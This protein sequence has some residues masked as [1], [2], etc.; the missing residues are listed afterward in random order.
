M[1]PGNVTFRQRSVTKVSAGFRQKVSAAP[2]C[3]F[4]SARSPT[5]LRMDRAA[6]LT[7]DEAARLLK[8]SLDTLETWIDKGVIAMSGRGVDRASLDEV[9]T[10]VERLR[11]SGDNR[12]LLAVALSRLEQ[13]DPAWRQQAQALYRARG[14]DDEFVSAAPGSDWDPED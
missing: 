3:P 2:T 9:A 10:Q 1:S 14:T 7:R 12:P 13:E 5:L 4:E 6:T 8:V 11:E